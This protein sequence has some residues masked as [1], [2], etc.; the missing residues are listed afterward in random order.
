MKVLKFYGYSDD[1]F[2]EYG[3]THEDVDN[4]ASLESIQCIVD[5]KDKGRIMVIG[6]YSA[7]NNGCWMVG[8]SKVDEEDDF[9]DWKIQ[10][11]EA[12]DCEYSIMA[13]I[14]IPDIDFELIWFNNGIG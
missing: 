9:P 10:I 2:G 13:T 3:I 8:I 5:C 6:Q 14:E 12:P 7:A 11:T 4:C 1:T